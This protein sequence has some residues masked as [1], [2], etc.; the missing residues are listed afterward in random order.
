MLQ[1]AATLA[2]LSA[3]NSRSVCKQANVAPPRQLAASIIR[4]K[5]KLD[6]NVL[7]DRYTLASSKNLLFT[8]KLC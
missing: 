5:E 1:A 8:K 7:A 6:H 3:I 4:L 2:S